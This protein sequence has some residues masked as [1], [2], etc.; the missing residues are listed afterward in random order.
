MEILL[1][2]STNLTF[3]AIVC[4]PGIKQ[5]GERAAFDNE[6]YI[7]SSSHFIEDPAVLVQVLLNPGVGGWG[8][9]GSL[10]TPLLILTL[11]TLQCTAQF[12]FHHNAVEGEMK[13][14]MV[15]VTKPFLAPLSTF[16]Q[17]RGRSGNNIEC[18]TSPP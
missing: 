12:F 10:E 1:R 11:H 4:L 18:P 2:W 7:I 8:E 14:R 3:S 9:S 6:R 17:V 16:Q 5:K 15:R 13:H